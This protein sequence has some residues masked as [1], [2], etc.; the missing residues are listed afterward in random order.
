LTEL[1]LSLFI[2]WFTVKKD[3]SCRSTDSAPP[4]APLQKPELK[5]QLSWDKYL[6]LVNGRLMVKRLEQPSTGYY[7][8]KQLSGRLTRTTC[9]YKYCIYNKSTVDQPEEKLA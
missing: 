5:N 1:F 7:L 4:F 6:H 8:F 9:N 3:L 2:V